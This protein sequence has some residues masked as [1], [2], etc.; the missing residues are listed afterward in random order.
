[1][2]LK[3]IFKT[4]K[5]IITIHIIHNIL[6]KSLFTYHILYLYYFLDFEQVPISTYFKSFCFGLWWMRTVPT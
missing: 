2:F 6:I 5:Y 4:V 3:Y 1:M